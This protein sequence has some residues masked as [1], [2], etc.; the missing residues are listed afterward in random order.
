MPAGVG[1]TISL[2]E[3]FMQVEDTALRI[4]LNRLLTA[5][6]N[7]VFSNLLA[8]FIQTFASQ[9]SYTTLCNANCHVDERLAR[10]LLMCH[11]RV[12]GDETRC[13]MTSFPPC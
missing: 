3:V 4:P 11:D 2:Y 7:P 12:D 5:P 8:R 10:G 1:G 9:I 6:E 13:R